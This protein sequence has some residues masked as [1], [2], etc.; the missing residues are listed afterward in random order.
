MSGSEAG[1]PRGFES[2]FFEL[3]RILV[4]IRFQPHVKIIQVWIIS[5]VHLFRDSLIRCGKHISQIHLQ[6]NTFLAN[7]SRF[8]KHFDLSEKLGMVLKMTH[9]SIIIN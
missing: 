5:T 3:P 8:H 1:Q 2:N 4:V 7:V 6:E 9:F